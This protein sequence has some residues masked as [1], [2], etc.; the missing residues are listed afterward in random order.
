MGHRRRAR[1]Q[2]WDVCVRP[3]RHGRGMGPLRRRQW[4]R[5]W[6]GVRVQAQRLRS[7]P[8]RF[9]LGH[10]GDD[11]VGANNGDAGLHAES[12]GSGSDVAQRRPA[13]DGEPFHG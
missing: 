7:Y 13:E 9:R 8:R 3:R 4:R 10:G 6:L 12:P 1:G 5:Y 2:A 11:A